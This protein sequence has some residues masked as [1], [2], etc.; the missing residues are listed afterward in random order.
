MQA[1]LPTPIRMKEA[2]FTLCPLCQGKDLALTYDLKTLKVFKCRACSL[3]FLNPYFP[4]SEMISFYSDK[5]VMTEINP[6]LA[7]YYDNLEGS[8]TERVFD[9]SV[10]DLSELMPRPSASLLDIACGN[11]FFLSRAKRKGW[12]VKGVDCS[13]ESSLAALKDFQIQVDVS[14]FEN[15]RSSGSFDC[16]SLW[17]FIEHVPNPKE[18]LQKAKAFLKPGGVLLVATPNHTSLIN[19][20]AGLFYRLT[21][22]WVQAP[23]RMLFVPEHILYFDS[24][25]LQRALEENGFEVAKIVKT[26]T[27]IDRY[28]THWLFNFTAK[29]LLFFSKI[30]NAGNRVMIF[31]RKKAR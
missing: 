3:K 9:Q 10:D 31:A 27:D 14:D 26:G 28:Q 11:G 2:F 16:V 13:S 23:L 20:W 22:G 7:H 17:D 4:P 29:A 19:F 21:F 15:Y 30:F 6:R 25:T 5:R 24:K 12:N 18:L 8:L 1:T